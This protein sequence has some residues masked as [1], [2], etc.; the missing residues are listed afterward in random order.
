LARGARLK[1]G[2][3]VC[4]NVA[5]LPG[6]PACEIVFSFV[7]PDHALPPDE[8]NL[9]AKFT[10]QFAALGESWLTR[11]K[12]AQ[13]VAKLTAMSFSEANHLSSTDANRRYFRERGDGLNAANLEQMMRAIVWW[14]VSVSDLQ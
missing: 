14:K 7:L 4:R 11:F 3:C 12:P 6:P 1:I 13:L 5:G 8:A 2:H 10:A 9:A